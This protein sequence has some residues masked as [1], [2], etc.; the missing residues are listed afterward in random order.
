M[1]LM[2]MVLKRLDGLRKVL[3]TIH[4]GLRNEFKA[5]QG[6]RV[7]TKLTRRQKS[8]VPATVLYRG[9]EKNI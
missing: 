6:T 9:L 7:V 4:E 1:M 3:T 2:S 5:Y 8:Y